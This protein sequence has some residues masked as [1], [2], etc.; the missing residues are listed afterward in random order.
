M[1]KKKIGVLWLFLLFFSIGMQAQ[2]VTSIRI[3]EVLV[4]NED[5]FVDDYGKRSGWVELYNGSAGTVNIGGCFLTNDKN[6]PKKYP[7]PKGDV[8]T[9]ISP[10][11]HILF[12]A[13]GIASRGTF[14]LNFTLDPTKENYIA[15]Y[16]SD[17]RTLV[18]EIVIPASQS[19]DIS[20][21]RRVD[22]EDEWVV[23]QK[24]TPSTNNL[25]LD[26]NEKLDNFK[27]NDPVG[28]GMTVTAMAVVFLGL[29]L[30][31]LFFKWVGYTAVS[32]SK[33]RAQKTT[34]VVTTVGEGEIS[35]EIL[36]AISAA[37]Y[38]LDEDVHDMENTVLTIQKVTRNYSPW[39]SKIYGL[40]E[41]PK[42]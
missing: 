6:D 25:T 18:D 38:E 24:V 41:L 34:G 28:I 12:W 27:T 15:L 5:N 40:R 39:S 10:R 42:K 9:K 11:Q 22:G 36:A 20:Y 2:R 26:S 16:D 14:H 19:A 32:A 3:N 29:I 1:T 8:L 31:Y 4:I 13:D 33:R 21:G 37:L 7:I 17:G 23:L 30:L 35:G